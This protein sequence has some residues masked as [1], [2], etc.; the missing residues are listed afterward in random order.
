M[1]VMPYYVPTGE[2]KKRI[3]KDI[4]KTEGILK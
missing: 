1:T 2:L 4:K 3:E